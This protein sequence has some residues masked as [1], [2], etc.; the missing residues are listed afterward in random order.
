[1]AIL[2]SATLAAGL[3]VLP[4]AGPAA[5]AAHAGA[6][7]PATAGL[8]GTGQAASA[9]PAGTIST[10]A[11]GVGGPA[12]AT[13]VNLGVATPIAGTSSSPCGVSFAQGQLLVADNWTVRDI[14]PVSGQL[15]TP[16]GTAAS[17]PFGDGGPAASTPVD[18]CSVAADAAG[19]LVLADVANDRI[20]VVPA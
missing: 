8:A 12:A 18:T 9:A 3:P 11:G 1:M 5:A 17:G 16:I 13:S 20:R 14:D 4:G 19:N 6:D 15:T 10:I 7:F 2:A